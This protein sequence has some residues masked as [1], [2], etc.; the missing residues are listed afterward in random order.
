MM[1]SFR[2]RHFLLLF[3]FVV[4]G[5]FIAFPFGIVSQG[6]KLSYKIRE[7]VVPGNVAIVF[8]A[9][10]TAND[11]PSDV[12][13]DR[14]RVASE[15]F[16]QGKVT[17]LLVSGDNR[18]EDHN[19]PEVMKKSLVDDF[20]VPEGAIVA[21]YAGRRTYDTC[22]RAKTIWGVDRAVLVSQGFHLYRAIWTCEHM[23]IESSGISAS[24]RPYIFGTQYK[25]REVLAIYKA[26]S[27]VYF[28]SP[29][30]IGGEFIIDIDV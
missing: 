22:I 15:L 9:G 24:L 2:L 16:H 28:L 5:F 17:T 8:G 23:G 6:K 21:D 3:F 13:Y 26:F 4:M 10:L 29:A 14:L 11:Q 18:F 1:P 20:S 30:Y 25:V 12:L 7:D 27:D 19:E